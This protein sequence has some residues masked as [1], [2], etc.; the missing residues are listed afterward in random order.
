MLGNKELRQLQAWFD[1]TD[2]NRDGRITANELR[3]QK[4]KGKQLSLKTCKKLI[5][6]FDKDK[7]G[8]VDFKSYAQLYKF[9]NVMIDSF[10]KYDT[11]RNGK[12]DP[13]EISEALRQGGF[14]FS[15]ETLDTLIQ[16]YTVR[17]GKP[18]SGGL[19]QD[20]FI[21][22]S[23]FLGQIKSTFHWTDADNDGFVDL[24]LETF[25]GIASEL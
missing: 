8:A 9:V 11:D 3:S 21:E 16:R 12:L 25:I 18:K 20:D 4:F 1:R 17:N 22:L 14:K 10:K 19:D 2:T 24:S 6:V 7:H 5:K 23:A 13:Y 15:K